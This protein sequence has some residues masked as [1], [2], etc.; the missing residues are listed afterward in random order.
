MWLKVQEWLPSMSFFWKQIVNYWTTLIFTWYDIPECWLTCYVTDI[1]ANLCRHTFATLSFVAEIFIFLYVGMDALDIEKWRFVSDRYSIYLFKG[2]QCHKTFSYWFRIWNG[3]TCLLILGFFFIFPSALEN[4]LEWV[5]C[6]WD[7][8]WLEE[9]PLFS[10]CPF[11]PTW[12]RSLPTR[13]ST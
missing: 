13:K 1:F 12:Q 8:F 11:Y 5:R 2:D 4:Q 10:P 3:L 9:Q 7:W 6:F